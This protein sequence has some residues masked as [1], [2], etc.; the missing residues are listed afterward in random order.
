[1]FSIFILYLAAPTITYYS[2]AIV[3]FEGNKVAL[4][5]NATNDVDAVNPVQVSWYYRGMLVK[6]AGKYVAISDIRNNATGQ[7]HSVLSFNPVNYTNDGEY[8]CRASNYPLSFT[9]NNI[10]LTVECELHGLQML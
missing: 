9:E 4:I 7:I 1:M 8:T 10:K 3:A 2:P 5:C 6:P